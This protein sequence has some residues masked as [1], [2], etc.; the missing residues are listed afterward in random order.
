MIKIKDRIISEDHPL[1]FIAEA[2]VN[3]NGSLELGKKLIDVAKES[4]ADAVKFQT[5]RADELNTKNAPKATYH[6]ETT[7]S[8]NSQS[9]YD[10]LK[11]QEIS[12]EMHIELIEYCKVCP[13]GLN[14]ILPDPL[15]ELV[16]EDSMIGK[17][18]VDPVIDK[19]PVLALEPDME[20][21]WR[22]AIYYKSIL[23]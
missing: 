11:T 19:E 15:K 8:D 17:T 1:F 13:S 7:G 6:V 12:E 14:H 18:I 4:G 3:H 20:V 9:W 22:V 5:F 21:D 2:G 10:L 16:K 23:L